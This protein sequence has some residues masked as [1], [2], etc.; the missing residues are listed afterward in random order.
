MLYLASGQNYTEGEA[1][2]LEMCFF[3]DI[4]FGFI[5]YFLLNRRRYYKKTTESTFEKSVKILISFYIDA[6]FDL[7]I[8]K[9]L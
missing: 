6:T 4:F 8:L 3:K 9:E 5:N 1:V 2:I 7:F